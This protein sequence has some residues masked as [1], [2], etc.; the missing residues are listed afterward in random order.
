MSAAERPRGSAGSRWRDALI[1]LIVVQAI[2]FLLFRPLLW[3]DVQMLLHPPAATPGAD[4]LGRG[5]VLM[6]FGADLV[7]WVL[8]FVAVCMVIV[9]RMGPIAVN[10]FK[11]A[12]RN[13]ILYL[14]LFF[15]LILMG[16]SGIIKE[17]AVGAQDRIIRDLGL[18]CI[19]FFG[20]MVAIFVGISLV[21]TELDKK[22]IYT[23]VSKPLHRYQ[24]LLGKFFGLL[25]TT[26]I[27]VAVM[28]LFFFLVVNYQ[29]LTTDAEIE[30]V[31]LTRDAAGSF[32][33]VA[34]LGWVK[35]S[36]LLESFGK[37]AVQSVGNVFGFAYGA[38]SQNL[39]IQIVMTCLELM[40]VTAFAILY[41]AFST[42]TL[43]AVFTVMTFLAG[44]LNEDIMRFGIQVVKNAMK[45][46]G[47]TSIHDLPFAVQLKIYVVKLAALV[48][49]NLDSLNLSSQVYEQHTMSVWRFP[50][51]Y[52]ICYTAA[53]LM[54]AIL[55]F[56]R[57]NFK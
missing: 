10:T 36:F 48:V 54:F 9:D 11:E 2:V 27:I 35:A 46:V 33:P 21:Y 23:I 16:S 6:N 4:A 1:P 12:V 53:V 15:A 25:L 41:S 51:L 52:A 31:L 8:A 34:H 26:Y 56:R 32:Q 44:R 24:Y 42:P 40:I 45:N 3:H 19:S 7:C 30:K 13:R 28:T 38:V 20:L 5:G 18:A 22:S 29:A 37:A 47:A 55:I 57:R 14:I 50:V 43:S 39:M 49:P 17:L